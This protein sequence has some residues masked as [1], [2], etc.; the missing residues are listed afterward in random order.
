M[1]V[2]RTR[3]LPLPVPVTLWFEDP[4]SH[5]EQWQRNVLDHLGI[6]DWVRIPGDVEYGLLGTHASAMVREH[7]LVFPANAYTHLGLAS[8]FRGGSLISGGGGDE[9]FASPAAPLI[10]ALSGHE[11]VRLQSIA[12]FVKTSL[13]ARSERTGVELLAGHSWIDAGSKKRLERAVGRSYWANPRRFDVALR[14]WVRDRYYRSVTRSLECA[15][16]STGCTVVA[17]FL[18]PEFMAAFADAMGMGGPA[19]RTAAMQQLFGDVLPAET[20]SRPT[21]A[22]FTGALYQI[23]RDF[24]DDWQGEGVPAGLVDVE[25]LRRLWATPRPHA[26]TNLLLQSAFFTWNGVLTQ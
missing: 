1:F 3:E 7:G 18:H 19:S 6:S 20:V 5:E 12:H 14:N 26:A 25:A 10:R 13:P 16:E 4:A 8:P 9:L 11:R 22:D 15:G 2:S 21:K 23:D 24:L 17:P